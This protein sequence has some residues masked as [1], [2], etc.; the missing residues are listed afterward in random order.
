M[1]VEEGAA[2]SGDG[3]TGAAEHFRRHYPRSPTA[4]DSRPVA[5]YLQLSKR[6]FRLVQPDG[7]PLRREVPA[8]SQP[9]G[10]IFCGRLLEPSA[11][12]TSRI[13]GSDRPPGQAN[14]GDDYDWEHH[15]RGAGQ[16]KRNRLGSR[17]LG[18]GIEIGK[19]GWEA[20]IH[21][22]LPIPLSFVRGAGS[23]NGRR[24][25][26]LSDSQG[27]GRI[28]NHPGSRFTARHRRGRTDS[29]STA[30]ASTR[31]FADAQPEAEIHIQGAFRISSGT[32]QR[33]VEPGS[34]G[35][36]AKGAA[37]ESSPGKRSGVGGQALCQH[38]K[39]LPAGSESIRVYGAG[40][41]ADRL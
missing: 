8:P 15:L 38:S 30:F 27:D 25:V 4:L 6:R 28:P 5:R 36:A 12:T 23:A 14:P 9:Q 35:T 22:H 11:M 10:R 19:G 16:Q 3:A 39:G 21:P 31:T 26:R 37:T 20:Q 40:A 41:G 32:V 29:N 17:L 2:G 7:G 34:T 13:F 33:T 1:G 18:P 24:G